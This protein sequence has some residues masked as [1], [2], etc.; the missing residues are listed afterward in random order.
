MVC[1]APSRHGWPALLPT[2]A[3]AE[4]RRKRPSKPQKPGPIHPPA[5][6]R[7]GRTPVCGARPCSP[8]L[9]LPSRLLCNKW[10]NPLP[11][12]AKG[13]DTPPGFLY[14]I[15]IRTYVCFGG[16]SLTVAPAPAPCIAHRAVAGAAFPAM[17]RET[18]LFLGQI[19]LIPVSRHRAVG[20]VA[21]PG[22][23]WYTDRKKGAELCRMR[24]NIPSGT[25]ALS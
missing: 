10:H 16:G 15:R 6:L 17:R 25:A 24:R 22:A 18:G 20:F 5:V 9:L 4:P 14:N 1:A 21:P 8:L 3:P 7:G 11:R 23:I 13:L 19:L 2:E 12:T